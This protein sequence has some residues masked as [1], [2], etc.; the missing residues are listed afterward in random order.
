MPRAVWNGAVLAES[1]QTVKLEGNHYFPPE[2]LN[3]EYFTES[4]TTSTC[5]WKG[6]ARY[7]DVTVEGKTNPA[8][9]WHYPDPRPA[10]RQIKDHVASWHG[11]R[12]ERAAADQ[13]ADDRSGL[14]GRPGAMFAAS[15]AERRRP[16]KR[17]HA[18]SEQEQRAERLPTLRRSLQ[19]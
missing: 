7:Y 9:A 8:A 10:A 5:P 16:G 1:S 11:V 15:R 13:A 3:R 12:V 14:A 19:W 17:P 4:S 2:S 18:G 6:H